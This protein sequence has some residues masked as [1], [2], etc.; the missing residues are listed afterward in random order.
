MKLPSDF[1]IFSPAHLPT[2]TKPLWAHRRANSLPAATAWARSFSWWG[3]ARSWPP[4]WRSKPSPSRSSAITTHSVCHP[5]RPG[6][7]GDGHDGS[8]GLTF[9]QRAKS[10]AEPL[11]LVDLHPGAGPHVVERLAGFSSP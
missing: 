7:H 8:P 4:P 1:D 6:P 11:L 9:F 5:G 2:T 3:K 10:R